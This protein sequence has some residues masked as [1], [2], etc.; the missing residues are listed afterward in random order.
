MIGDAP[1]LADHE[2]AEVRFCT[3]ARMGAAKNAFGPT[4]AS[5]SKRTDGSA[6]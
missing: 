5:E 3:K 1:P 2:A 6:P 4:S